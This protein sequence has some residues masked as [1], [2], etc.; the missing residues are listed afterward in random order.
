MHK[1]RV[2]R[3]SVASPGVVR[4]R[5]FDDPVSLKTYRDLFTVVRIW[6]PPVVIQKGDI[7][8]TVMSFDLRQGGLKPTYHPRLQCNIF[9]RSCVWVTDSRFDVLISGKSLCNTT[10][11]REDRGCR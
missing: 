11:N 9:R 10:G 6:C 5:R 7:T 2:V 8:D 4:S 1:V 3:G